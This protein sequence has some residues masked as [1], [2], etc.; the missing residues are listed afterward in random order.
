MRMLIKSENS[1][2]VPTSYDDRKKIHLLP[3]GLIHR[4]HS[5][6]AELQRATK[7][8]QISIQDLSIESSLVCIFVSS[9]FLKKPHHITDT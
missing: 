4:N 2:K 7:S 5:F 3:F 8:S 6:C 9:F 1:S